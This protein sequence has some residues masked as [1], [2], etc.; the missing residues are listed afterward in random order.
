M[1]QIRVDNSSYGLGSLIRQKYGDIW[2]HA[3][4]ESRSLG[5][6]E[7]RYAQLE[8]EA[9]AVTWAGEKFANFLIGTRFHIE[10]DRKPLGST[11]WY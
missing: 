1:T 6:T 3:A 11:P 5:D 9:L 4:F 7:C 8:K 2:K 10:N